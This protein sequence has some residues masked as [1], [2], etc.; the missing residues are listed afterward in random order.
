MTSLPVRL[1]GLLALFLMV[2]A[3]LSGPASQPVR[4]DERAP[5]GQQNFLEE[6]RTLYRKG[7]MPGAAQVLSRALEAAAPA[8]RASFQIRRLLAAAREAYGYYH[9]AL[10]VLQDGLP[11]LDRAAL[12]PGA[13][14]AYLSQM[15]DLYLTMGRMSEGLGILERAEDLATAAGDPT[16][17]ADILNNRGNALELE[18]DRQDIQVT[19]REGIDLLSGD[20]TAAAA[21]IRSRLR[22]NLARF[23]LEGSDIAVARDLLAL[24]MAD[25]ALLPED[26]DA[27]VA[28][29]AVGALSLAISEKGGPASASDAQRAFAAFRKAREIGRRIGDPALTASAAGHLGGMYRA[30]GR[31]DAALTLTREAVFLSREGRFP[32]E[33]YRWEWQLGL[34]QEERGDLEAAADALQRAVATL[35]PIRGELMRARRRRGEVFYTRIRPVYLDRARLLLTSVEGLPPGQERQERLLTAREVMETLKTAE[36][37]DFFQ[38]PCLTAQAG[39]Q[40]QLDRA[41]AGTA[42][43][44]P[45]VFADRIALL[46]TLPDGMRLE[47]VPVDET[48]LDRA[49]RRFRELLQSPETGRRYFYYARRLHDW[50]VGPLT[51]SLRGNDIHTLIVAPD[52][53]L[54]LIPFS[55]LHDGERFLSQAYGVATVPGVALTDPEPIRL[56]DPKVLLGGLSE[57]R[58]GFMPLPAVPEELRSIQSLMGGKVLL[59]ADY[60][61][62]NLKAAFQRTDYSIIHLATHGEFGGSSDA[63]FLLTSEGHLTMDRLERFIHLGR[64]RKSPVELLTLSACQTALGDAR[65][66]LGLGGVAV[67][68]G[69]R[70]AL[71]TLWSVDDEAT[72]L[73]VQAF[74]SAFRERAD[75]KAQALQQ[76]QA[77]LLADAAFH[78][79]AY[80]AP[81]LLIGN[82]R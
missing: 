42:M 35:T 77:R 32:E 56:S 26:H 39:R 80:W 81:F 15:G 67:K 14:A 12:D 65:S 73:A 21:R 17:L 58:E 19:Y 46:L 4:A 1:N 10:T 64:F 29:V 52:G 20:K 47:T 82:W 69:A 38:D 36:L 43:I 23:H 31:L 22:L 45:I 61:L 34:L 71:A 16:V 44:Y 59:N 48:R 62:G 54:R 33:L 75:E 3:L 74:Y 11:H 76:A 55:A 50:L 68:A 72:S 78:H 2:F 37:E 66:A 63:T 25:A 49:V 18:G 70:S 6:G 9:S 27:G 79:P 30:E 60:T 13:R 41:P 57:A 53:V 24:A 28:W 40:R 8:D 5:G 51:A 7:D